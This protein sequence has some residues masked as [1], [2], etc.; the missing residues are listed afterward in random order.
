MIPPELLVAN[1]SRGLA[2]DRRFVKPGPD[3]LDEVVARLAEVD[4]A[5]GVNDRKTRMRMAETVL[6]RMQQSGELTPAQAQWH[7]Q[8]GVANTTTARQFPLSRNGTTNGSNV[9]SRANVSRPQSSGGRAAGTAPPRPWW[10]P[11]R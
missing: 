10:N 7:R 4:K 6:D 11:L 8:Q 3:H 1:S 9:S 2:G 5:A